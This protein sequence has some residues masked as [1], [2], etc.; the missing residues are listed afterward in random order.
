M[1]KELMI[2]SLDKALSELEASGDLVVTTAIPS[3]VSEALYLSIINQLESCAENDDLPPAEIRIEA[4]L[5]K[6]SD[7]IV[8]LFSLTINEAKE[9]S[10]NFYKYC[11]GFKSELEI[12]DYFAHEGPMEIALTAYFC[13]E[14]GKDRFG[15]SEY[16]DWRQ[17]IYKQLK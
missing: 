5:S 4:I 2:E 9:V 1:N 3:D 8:N 7:Y 14:L 17:E 15:D 12:A 16:L 6:S 11:K 10:Y 13:I